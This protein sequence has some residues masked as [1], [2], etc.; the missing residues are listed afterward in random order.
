MLEVASPLALAVSIVFIVREGRAAGDPSAKVATTLGRAPGL[1]EQ[2]PAE[3][4][5]AREQ[6]AGGVGGGRVYG[7]DD[8]HQDQHGSD[9]F[10]WP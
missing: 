5:V 9:D 10:R 4:I 7:G 8:G 1:A 3:T 2:I 6:G